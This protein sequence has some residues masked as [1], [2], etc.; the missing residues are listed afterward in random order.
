MDEIKL[1]F[2]AYDKCYNFTCFLNTIWY[3]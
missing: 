1:A 3:F 2:V